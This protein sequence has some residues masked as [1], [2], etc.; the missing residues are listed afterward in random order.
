MKLEHL[1]LTLTDNS[2]IN[3]YDY[4]IDTHIETDS[5]KTIEWEDRWG[6]TLYYSIGSSNP[7]EF[8][9]DEIKDIEVY[10]EL[11]DFDSHDK[12][13]KTL[14]LELWAGEDVTQVDWTVEDYAMRVVSDSSG[15]R[16]TNAEHYHVDNDVSRSHLVARTYPVT[17]LT[18]WDWIANET[19]F[20]VTANEN[21]RVEL[22][23]I[24]FELGSSDFDTNEF[25]EDQINDNLEIE[26]DW[27][28]YEYDIITNEN[29]SD[30]S[31]D[32]IRV[33]FEEYPRISASASAD[34]ELDWLRSTLTNHLS[35][36]YNYNR[37]LRII[38]VGYNDNAL[39]SWDYIKLDDDENDYTNVNLPTDRSY[40]NYEN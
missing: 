22:Y 16:M 26:I 12:T 30:I 18:D 32:V 40:Y 33:K 6:D 4:R 14:E 39:E 36:E 13:N 27:T 11:S 28:D 21:S 10:I 25:N 37:E 35:G 31:E 8:E 5:G 3:F 9:K 1:Y 15:D 19:T 23:E 34:V 2:D 20:T 38:W 29:D 17:T 24:D 7:I